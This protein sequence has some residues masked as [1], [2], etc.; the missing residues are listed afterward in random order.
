MNERGRGVAAEPGDD[1][2]VAHGHGAGAEDLEGVEVEGERVALDLPAVV[3]A[4]AALGPRAHV[5]ELLA[6]LHGEVAEHLEGLQ[7][8][9][10]DDG[11]AELA[12]VVRH[13]GEGHGELAGGQRAALHEVRAEQLAGDVGRHELGDAGADVDLF[14]D[15]ADGGDEEAGGLGRGETEQ[16]RDRGDGGELALVGAGRDDLAGRRHGQRPGGHA[17]LDGHG[18]VRDLGRGRQRDRV[19]ARRPRLDLGLVEVDGGGIEGD[20]RQRGD[21]VLD[22]RVAHG[23]LDLADGRR[24]G[25]L[26]VLHGGLDLAG[27]IAEVG[28]EEAG[29][30]HRRLGR[31]RHPTAAGGVGALH[32]GGPQA[33]VVVLD[34]G[35]GQVEAEIEVEIDRAVATDGQRRRRRRRPGGDLAV[36]LFDRDDREAVGHA[37][38]AARHAVE[39]Q[40]AGVDVH[41]LGVHDRGGQGLA[42]RSPGPGVGRGRRGRR[43][44]QRHA[45]RDRRAPRHRGGGERGLLGVGVGHGLALAPPHLLVERLDHLADVARRDADPL[46]EHPVGERVAELGGARPALG[47]VLAQRLA[48]DVIEAGRDVAAELIEPRQLGVAHHQEHVELGG[49]GEQPPTAQHLGQHHADREQIAAGVDRLLDHL[50]GRHVAVLALERA[51]LGAVVPPGAGGARDAEVDE[52]DVAASGQE[53]VRRR[54]VAVDHAEIVAGVVA[55]VV[56]EVEGVEDLV[57]DPHRVLER[58]LLALPRVLA[59]EAE[60][61]DA[62]DELHRDEQ[63]LVD[64]PELVGLGDLGVRQLG[65]ELGLVDEHRRVHR[66]A[67]E[68]RQQALDDDLALEV[69]LARGRGEEQLRHATDR[70]A[71]DQRV[72][73]EPGWK[74]I[75]HG[76]GPS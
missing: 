8:A 28:V 19:G 16:D 20:G 62:V 34:A 61:V 37:Q 2:V 64:A 32:A 49:G 57:A 6:D 59:Q 53:Q 1:D 9:E 40:H 17:R 63:R 24:H 42:P 25:G 12:A 69:V 66:L 50:L 72:A 41:R 46:L 75:T 18:A 11:V 71:L 23:G 52:L 3:P 36:V 30:G 47:G 27:E 45:G 76:S 14:L 67:R 22:G 5:D 43:G 58:R 39:R 21:G 38:L 44:G 15:P 70:D 31:H 7:E 48:Q 65:R 74:L 35:G 29:G 55:Q 56:R 51:R 54:D 33:E 13:H 68:V 26:Q 10:A 73:T 4:V 60:H